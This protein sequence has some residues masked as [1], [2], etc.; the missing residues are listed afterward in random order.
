MAFTSPNAH[1]CHER[2]PYYRTPRRER[3]L[4]V[5]AGSAC[6]CKQDG[7]TSGENTF[8]VELVT[9]LDDALER[10]DCRRYLCGG[11]FQRSG[12]GADH[13]TVGASLEP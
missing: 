10:M 2:F 12:A 7:I 6:D 3:S 9:R 11:D 1:T 13:G 4:R 5:Q 8:H